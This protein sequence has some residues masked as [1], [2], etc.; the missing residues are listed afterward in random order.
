M[1]CESPPFRMVA[2][3]VRFNEEEVGNEEDAGFGGPCVA[4]LSDYLSV[5]LALCTDRRLHCLS[6]AGVASVEDAEELVKRLRLPHID[7]GVRSRRSSGCCTFRGNLR[8]VKVV[9]LCR[10]CCVQYWAL[11]DGLILGRQDAWRPGTIVVCRH[12]VGNTVPA[13]AVQ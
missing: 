5:F 12:D 9:A 13:V 8:C 11:V 1:E 6:A 7:G 2:V 3:E 4:A 10:Q